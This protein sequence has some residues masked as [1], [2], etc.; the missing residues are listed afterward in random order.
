M[1]KV[2]IFLL[3]LLL[4]SGLSG[5][6][7]LAGVSLSNTAQIG[8]NSLVLNG[9]G[10]RKKAFI[11]VYVAGLYLTEK[12]T[13]ASA[14]LAAD[15][16]RRT[17]MHFLFG[18]SESKMCGAWEEGLEENTPGAS[19]GLQQK[20]ANLCSY[21]EDIGKEEEIVATYLPGMGT[22]IQVKGVVKGTIEGKDF[23]DALFACWIGPEPPGEDFKLGLLG[24]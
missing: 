6:G 21:M 19:A 15:S 7:E 17:V 10:L 11:K 22:E 2:G 5:A 3:G 20:F 12:Q 8:E 24:K 1:R 16:A 9:L 4:V 18:V 14:V 13:D 23:A